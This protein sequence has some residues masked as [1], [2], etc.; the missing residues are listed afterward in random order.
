MASSQVCKIPN[1]GKPH[2]AAGYCSAHYQRNRIY[3][4][5]LEPF[6]RN[7]GARCTHDGCMEKAYAKGMC[8]PH[9]KA[10]RPVQWCRVEG[11]GGRVFSVGNQMCSKHYYRL[12]RHGGLD[13]KRTPNGA[14]IAFIDTAA[15]HDDPIACLLWPY[16]RTR[17]G[18]GSAK[19]DGVTSNA[20]RFV[21]ARV[22]GPAPSKIHEA[23]H[24]CGNRS[25]VNPHH[26]K[27]STPQENA[28]DKIDHGTVLR[29]ERH[30]NSILTADAVRAIRT[31]EGDAREVA[32]AHGVSATT[33]WMIRAGRSWS[34]VT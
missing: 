5:P 28:A 23:A 12:T 22:H 1:C 32:K 27:W 21:C 25:C 15:R 24:I 13:S 19:V 30:P 8:R 2:V 33:V 29:G 34:S 18:Y 7:P 9:Y 17:E 16:K 20:H 6:K 11:C 10:S 26:L 31:A 4:N 14:A 3:G